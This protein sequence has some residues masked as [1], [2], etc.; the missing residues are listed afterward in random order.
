MLVTLEEVKTYTRIDTDEED[1]LLSLLIENA[2]IYI[3][4]SYKAV[5]LI[6]PDK[7]PKCKLIALVLISDCYNNRDY[8]MKT[9]EKARFTVRSLINQ[10]QVCV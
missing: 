7:I 2:E 4:D 10:L 6:A 1:A 5:H 8:N 9:S 3:K